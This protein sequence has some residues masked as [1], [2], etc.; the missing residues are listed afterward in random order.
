MQRVNDEAIEWTYKD[1]FGTC[2]AGEFSD[3]K[4]SSV[5]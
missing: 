3:D 1:D 5:I 2:I 4:L